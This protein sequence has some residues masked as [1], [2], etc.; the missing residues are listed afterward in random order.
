V[1]VELVGETDAIVDTSSE[2]LASVHEHRRAIDEPPGLAREE[3]RGSGDLFM[4]TDPA[5]GR[6]VAA[7]TINVA[8]Q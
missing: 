2:G 3:E 7:P 6:L 8:G 1:G 4:Q 5:C